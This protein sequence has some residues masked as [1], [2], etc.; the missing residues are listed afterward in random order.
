LRDRITS[1]DNI[2]ENFIIPKANKIS[3]QKHA[4]KFTGKFIKRDPITKKLDYS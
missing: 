1:L 4:S 2:T 3:T